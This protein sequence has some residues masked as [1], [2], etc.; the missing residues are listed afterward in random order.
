MNRAFTF[1]HQV[2]LCSKFFS[3]KCRGAE[4]ENPTIGPN[5]CDKTF[6]GNEGYTDHKTNPRP[7]EGFRNGRAII[8]VTF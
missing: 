6:Y 2:S 4:G 3:G 1:F 7:K 8:K 5:L